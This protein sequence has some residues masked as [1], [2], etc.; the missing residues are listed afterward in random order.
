MT[1]TRI[2]VLAGLMALPLVAGQAFAS[3]G[4]KVV[5]SKCKA[6]HDITDAQKA[7]V[8]PPLWG[9]AGRK[10]ATA[11]TYL[12]K[13]SKEMAA[14][15][16]EGM[17][18]DDANLDKFLA[19]PKDFVPKTKMMFKGLTDEDRAAAITYLKTLGAAPAAQ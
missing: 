8:G 7:K 4:E 11:E 12:K 16:E 18:W 15:G 5:G 14:K 19:S 2:M 1:N 3:D 13:Y 10:V 9:V 6:C 17:V